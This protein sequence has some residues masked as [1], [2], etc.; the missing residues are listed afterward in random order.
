M[1]KTAPQILQIAFYGPMGVGKA[2]TLQKLYQ[3]IPAKERGEYCV[4]PDPIEQSNANTLFF[5]YNIPLNPL[6]LAAVRL[7]TL[8]GKDSAFLTLFGSTFCVFLFDCR[9]EKLP[10][11]LAALEELKN[12]V[13]SYGPAWEHLPLIVQL[14][15]LDSPNSVSPEE[16]P[17]LLDRPIAACVQTNPASGSGIPELLLSILQIAMHYVPQGHLR[18]YK[19]PKLSKQYQERAGAL[20]QACDLAAQCRNDK[21]WAFER[22]T[23]AMALYPEL[24]FGTIKSL[25]YLEND[26]FTSWNEGVEPEVKLFWKKVAQ[27]QLPFRKRDRAREILLRGSI[28]ND[29]EFEIITDAISDDRFNDSEIAALGKLLAQY[30]AKS[31]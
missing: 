5:D 3:T 11:N 23:K 13:A 2:S 14:T 27:A 9:R 6:H 10:Q 1:N 28:R 25:A 30:E 7:R 12:H 21:P 20:A 18:T 29:L 19:F 24:G 17:S 16:V 22:A 4:I 8:S 15:W 31:R 26:F